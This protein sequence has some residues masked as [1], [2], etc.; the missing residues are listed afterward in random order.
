MT[1]RRTPTLPY[2]RRSFLTALAGL[3]SGLASA[4]WPPRL[5][6]A[7]PGPPPLAGEFSTYFILHK[8]PLPA[9]PVRFGT[10]GGKTLTIED[11][12][13][14]TVLMNFWAT[15]CQPCLVEMPSLDRL[16]EELGEAGLSVVTVSQDRGGETAVIPYFEQNRLTH[17][18][19]Y[20][21]PLGM[22]AEAYGI[23][24]LPT[25]LL[26]DPKGLVQG[27]LEGPAD[28]ASPEGLDLVRHYLPKEQPTAT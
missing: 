20:T 22:L 26:I 13:G 25:S 11:F 1:V 28:W 2:S 24:G 18:I 6:A 19:P 4:G 21:D 8:T 9:L 23:R 14:R 12:R 17:L 15:W 5:A 27:H 3:G 16:Q 7:D 10:V